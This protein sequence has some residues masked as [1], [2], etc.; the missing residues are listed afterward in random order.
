MFHSA[1]VEPTAFTSRAS[2]KISPHP[3]LSVGIWLLLDSGNWLRK[4][5]NIN[6]TI[7][8]KRGKIKVFSAGVFIHLFFMQFFAARVSIAYHNRYAGFLSA[9][10]KDVE[11]IWLY[12]NLNSG[13]LALRASALPFRQKDVR[14]KVS[15]FSWIYLM[16]FISDLSIT[17]V[18]NARYEQNTWLPV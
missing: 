11:R 8:F 6:V 4:V 3:Y 17:T 14:T 7:Q 16:W 2:A 18:P 10:R 5:I 9:L 15:V 12:Y 13:P 1:F